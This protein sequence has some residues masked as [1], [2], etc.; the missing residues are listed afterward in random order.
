MKP[1]KGGCRDCNIRFNQCNSPYAV[2]QPITRSQIKSYPAHHR[3]AMN[4]Y[5][6]EMT[7]YDYLDMG[8]NN[9]ILRATPPEVLHEWLLGIVSVIL[10]YLLSFLTPRSE[11]YLKELCA[12]IAKQ[13]SR[14]SDRSYPN[15]RSNVDVTSTTKKTAKEKLDQLFLIY[16]A[17]CTEGFKNDIINIETTSAKRYK[18]WHTLQQYERMSNSNP[19]LL[20]EI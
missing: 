3:K 15:I 1:T 2:C 16:L 10:T 11:Q 20:K 8:P 18:G 14:Q 7:A 9:C 5:D 6:I 13:S 4:F 12:D 17:F 19:F